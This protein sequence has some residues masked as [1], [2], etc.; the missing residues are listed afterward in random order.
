MLDLTKAQRR[1][2]VKLRANWRQQGKQPVLSELA[3]ELDIHYVS[4]KQHLEALER[5]NYL[6]FE[7]KGRGK[8]PVIVLMGSDDRGVP[9]VGEIA[10]GGL[11]STEEHLEGFI[12]VPGQE[13]RFALRVTGDSMSERILDGD[14]VIL[15]SGKP[16]GGEICAVRHEDE[17]TLKYLDLYTGGDIAL[18]RPHN[19]GYAPI[20]VRL[21]DIHVAGLYVGH[22]SG[23]IAEELLEAA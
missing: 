9:L 10:A 20:E 2:W 18:L 6:T 22:L 5:K 3:A 19:P 11:W 13:G 17:T 7:V 14:V 21:S 1:V 23:S 4:L 12:K 16:R 15:Q 8:A